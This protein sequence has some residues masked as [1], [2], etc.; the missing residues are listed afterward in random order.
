LVRACHQ[1]AHHLPSSTSAATAV[2]RLP[3]ISAERRSGMRADPLSIIRRWDKP[4]AESSEA[5]LHLK[6]GPN[7]AVNKPKPSEY[8]MALAACKQ[9]QPTASTLL[10]GHM[11][12]S[13]DPTPE[14]AS[15][16][17]PMPIGVHEDL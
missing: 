2:R 16:P 1:H 8:A 5:F 12:F 4:R 9:T 3:F 17:L 15:A 11:S 6:E 7:F 13:C 14:E 10:L